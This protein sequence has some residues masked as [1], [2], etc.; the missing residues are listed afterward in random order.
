MRK[1]A[2]RLTFEAYEQRD[3]AIACD[4]H[5]KNPMSVDVDDEFPAFWVTIDTGDRVKNLTLAEN[6]IAEMND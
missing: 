2:I 3:Y 4:Y 1:Y 5:L 6:L